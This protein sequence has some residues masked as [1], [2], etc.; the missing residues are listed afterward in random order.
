MFRLIVVACAKLPDVPVTFTVN[1]PRVAVL[2]TR[3][4]N[5]LD[6]VAGFGLKLAVTPLGSPEAVRL[7]VLLKPP[8]GVIVIVLWPLLPRLM[9][10]LLGEAESE[11]LGAAVT[12]RET[13][14]V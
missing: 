14:V 5:V 1:V 12:V 4:V 9:L 3:S 11:K 6:A 10:R 13:V 8:V 2:V 7:T